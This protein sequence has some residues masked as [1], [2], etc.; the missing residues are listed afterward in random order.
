MFK[1]R[2]FDQSVILLCVRWYLAYNL[3]LRDLEEMMA[4]RG[5]TVDHTTIH[6]WAVRFSPL[7]LE[8]FNR[9]KRAVTGKWHVDETYI[10][11][12]G[13]WTYLYRAIDTVGDTVEFW[14]SE[15]RDL[16]AAKRFFRKALERHGRPDRVVIHGSQT[17]HEAI[18][19]CDI[20]NRLQD[21]SRRRLKPFR[22]RRSQYL[23][24]RI[25]QDHRRI[26][27]RVR[28]MLGFKSTATAC[29]ILSGIEM[30][31]MMRK[32]RARYAFEILAA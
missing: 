4:E 17:N 30:I 29:T 11:V 2:Q 26:K 3:S 23:N 19:S 25:E 7:L 14:F 8:R 6:R 31:H 1:G 22:I 27:R 16:P 18:V 9:R 13:Q 32:R 20:T 15:Q 21:R 10:K 5:I 24:N 12:R 28:P